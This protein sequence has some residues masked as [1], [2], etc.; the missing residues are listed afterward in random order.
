MG[1]SLASADSTHSL[2]PAAPSQSSDSADRPNRHLVEEGRERGGRE[3]GI[4]QGESENDDKNDSRKSRQERMSG[5]REREGERL[6]MR[7]TTCG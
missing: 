6:P 1:V 4:V 2:P 7:S 3:R 5:E